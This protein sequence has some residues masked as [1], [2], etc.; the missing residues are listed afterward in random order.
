MLISNSHIIPGFGNK[1]YLVKSYSRPNDQPH[2]VCVRDTVYISCD[3]NCPKYNNK[4]FYGHT[5]GLAIKCKLVEKYASVLSKCRG[6]KVT[7]LA[8]QNINPSQVG[9]K[10]PQRIINSLKGKAEK[11]FRKNRSNSTEHC[12]RVI[13]NRNACNVTFSDRTAFPP[14]F[15]TTQ[16]ELLGRTF[17]QEVLNPQR[18]FWATF[19]KNI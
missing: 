18:F 19:S 3:N 13:S 5:I 17:L 11:R 15:S 4:G 1:Q 10:R 9:R 8:S 14:F 7:Q 2:F 16:V 6:K 12:Q